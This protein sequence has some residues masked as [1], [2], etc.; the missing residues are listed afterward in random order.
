MVQ[1]KM[2]T[3][4]VIILAHVVL[5]AA[6]G[7]AIWNTLKVPFVDPK[8]NQAMRAILWAGLGLILAAGILYFMGVLW[9]TCPNNKAL[10]TVYAMLAVA[11]IALGVYLYYFLTTRPKP[12]SY[13][14]PAMPI[15]AEEEGEV[16]EGE[17]ETPQP[18]F[19]VDADNVYSDFVDEYKDLADDRV[20]FSESLAT[21]AGQIDAAI[22]DFDKDLPTLLGDD[23]VSTL[24]AAP[25]NIKFPYPGCGENKLVCAP[26][27]YLVY[28]KTIEDAL[29][30]IQ[31]GA[32]SELADKLQELKE[33]Q[34]ANATV[35][36][37]IS[38]ADTTLKNLRAQ[39]KTLQDRVALL[40]DID[41]PSLTDRLSTFMNELLY[42]AQLTNY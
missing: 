17:E 16:E 3:A 34:E 38:T 11:T 37:N 31:T 29:T 40:A 4:I 32:Q 41:D 15:R 21:T 36:G 5:A 26:S 1:E 13:R 30:V 35:L 10:Y 14:V 18:L 27:D 8:L 42:A 20:E 33:C 6:Y 2:R 22:A 39:V 24:K 9:A 12:S 19:T 23:L 7:Y 28:L 25:Y